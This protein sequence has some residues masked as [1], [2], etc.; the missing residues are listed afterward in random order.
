MIDTATPSQLQF[1]SSFFEEVLTEEEMKTLNT[2]MTKLEK[3]SREKK[4]PPA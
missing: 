3:H 4:L 2:L 1:Q